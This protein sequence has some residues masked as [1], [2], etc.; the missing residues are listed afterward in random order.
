MKG[1][2]PDIDL[3]RLLAALDAE[4]RSAADDEVRESAT[5]CGRAPARIATTVR[6]VIDAAIAAAE[7]PEPRL[8]PA[9]PASRREHDDRRH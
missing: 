3:T 4:L 6:N 7:D 1:W 2:R 8:P 5:A 9:E